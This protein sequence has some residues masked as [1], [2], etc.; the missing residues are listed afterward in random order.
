MLRLC[1]L[2]TSDSLLP[3]LSLI[4]C[5]QALQDFAEFSV[6]LAISREVALS[7]QLLRALEVLRS[8]AEAHFYF[9]F[10]LRRGFFFRDGFFAKTS[11]PRPERAHALS[12]RSMLTG[13]IFEDFAIRR[14]EVQAG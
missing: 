9:V 11:A 12:Y 14:L 7:Q 13:S 3:F 10:R 6:F 2:P 5:G 1:L 4:R 8:K